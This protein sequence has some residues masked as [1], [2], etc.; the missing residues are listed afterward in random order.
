MC[1]LNVNNKLKTFFFLY[2]DASELSH[3]SV[4]RIRVD[5]TIYTEQQK[6]SALINSATGFLFGI[7]QVETI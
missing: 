6:A 2:L 7:L 3:S 5:R 4:Y 1:Y